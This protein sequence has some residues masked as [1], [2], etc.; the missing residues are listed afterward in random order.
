MVMEECKQREKYVNYL[1]KIDQEL[2]HHASQM[3]STLSL[4]NRYIVTA[5]TTLIW[6]GAKQ[7]KEQIFYCKNLIHMECLK[8]KGA[9]TYPS[10]YSA[11]RVFLMHAVKFCN[12]IQFIFYRLLELLE[13]SV[14]TFT[15]KHFLLGQEAMMQQFKEQMKQG[16]L[17]IDDKCALMHKYL[18]FFQQKLLDQPSWGS[19]KYGLII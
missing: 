5:D 12:L 7:L 6:G 10:P 11:T 18:Q 19:C 17:M 14:V 2:C 1:R 8:F 15:V 4:F 9:V 16:D 13:T 3:D